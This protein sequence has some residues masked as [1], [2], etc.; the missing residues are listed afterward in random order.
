MQVWI[1]VFGKSKIK[2][3]IETGESFNCDFKSRSK[4]LFPVL[5]APIKSGIRSYSNK[6]LSNLS[7]SAQSITCYKF[8]G[9][10]WKQTGTI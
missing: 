3:K 2:K 7:L 5:R 8:A 1:I 6:C 4:K 9:Y 10:D